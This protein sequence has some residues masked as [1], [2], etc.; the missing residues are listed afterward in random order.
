MRRLIRIL[1]NAATVLSLFFCLIAGGLWHRSYAHLDE[2][3]YDGK[4]LGVAHD[5]KL[6]AGAQWNPA[7]R[8]G[9]VLLYFQHTSPHTIWDGRGE[10]SLRLALVHGEECAGAV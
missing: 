5:E 9:A 10:G 4:T 8:Q 7:P 6:L 1:L 3:Q 2:L